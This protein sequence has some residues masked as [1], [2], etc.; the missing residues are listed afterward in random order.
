MLPGDTKCLNVAFSPISVGTGIGY[1]YEWFSNDTPDYTSPTSTGITTNTFPP[2]SNAVGTTYYYVVV[3]SPSCTSATSLVSG[4]YIVTANNTVTPASSSPVVCIG[5]ALP[6]PIT[7]TTVGSTGIGTPTGLPAGISAN[8]AAKA[9]T[10]YGTPTASGVFNYSIPLTGGCGTVNATGTITVNAVPAILT[11]SLS[12]LAKC[13]GTGN[14]SPIS[15]GT[16]QGFTYQWFSNDTPD[17]TSPTII[18]GATSNTYPPPAAT[19]GTTYYFVEVSSSGSCGSTVTSAVSGAFVVNPLPVVSFVTQPVAGNYCVDTDI[20]YSTQ[21]GETNYTWTIPGV[22]GTDYTITSGGNGSNTLVL[23]WLTSG[24]KSVSVNYQDAQGCGATA[25]ATSNSITVQKN[26]VTASSD[27]HPSSCFINRTITSFTHTTTLATGIGAP[28]GLPTGLSAV[29]SGNT[30]TVSGTVDASIL[31]GIYNYSIPLTGGCGTVAATGFIDVQPEYVFE[32]ITSV[33]PSNVGGI[34]TIRFTVDSSIVPDGTYEVTYSLGLANSG[35]GTVNVTVTNGIAVFPTI[36]ILSEDLT[37]LTISQ[38]KKVTDDCFVPLSANNVTFFGIQAV[39]FPSNGTFYVP[40][41]IYEITIKVWGGGGAGGNGPTGAGG[42]GGGY[43]SITIPVVP[44]EAIGMFIGTGGTAQG[45]G[46]FSYATRD[47]SDPDQLGSSL[48]YAN[49]GNGANGSTPGTGGSGQT[50]NGQNGEYRAT[51]GGKGG[52]AGGSGGNGAPEHNDGKK[53]E[54]GETPGGGGSGAN[55]NG[56]NAAGGNGGNGLIL[57][58]YPLPPVD[59][60]FNVIDDG[61]VS[62][63]TIIEFICDD[64]WAPPEGL[65]DFS[66]FV[67]GAGGGGGMGSG[68]GGGG[69]GALSTQ[70]VPSGSPYGFPANNDFTIRVGQGGQ[71]AQTNVIRGFRGGFSGIAGIVGGTPVLV[72][73]EGGGGGGS[74]FSIL[75]EGGL[76]GSNGGGGGANNTA[77]GDGGTGS[78]RAGGR[79]DF[80]T[81]QAFAG[82]GGGGIA[83]IGGEGKGAGLGQG[84]GGKGGNGVA[85]TMGDSTRYFG[86]GGGGVGFNFNGTQKIGFGGIAPN[87]TKLGGDGNLTV[88]NAIGQQGADKTGSG[89]GAGYSGGGKGGNGIVYIYYP[90]YRILGVEFGYF[91]AHYNPQNRSG[92]LRWATHKEW[93]NSHFEIERAVNGVSTWTKVGELKGQGYSDT[94]VEYEFIDTNLPDTGG[95]IYYR[96]REVN[97]NGLSGVSEVRAIQVNPI[98]E[99][100][101]W[102]AYPNPSDRG[103][104][105]TVT[106]Q[107]NSEYADGQFHVRVSDVRGI[108]QNFTVKNPQEVSGVIN[109]HL[110]NA[111]PGL[112]I[113]QIFWGNRSQ[114]LK[115]VRQ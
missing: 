90:T 55:G 14:F 51:Y 56:A 18:P 66:T 4:A 87:G 82:G 21:G 11:P 29:W 102:T 58:S 20:S 93:E 46:G 69:S 40:A 75:G 15:V 95:H 5:A 13:E 43:S 63:T 107:S 60:C 112:Y 37:S 33:S 57:V 98:N 23:R 72:V 32:S 94:T 2:P 68:A 114:H 26:T 101:Y 28:T 12:G 7:H 92:V 99:S 86:A 42:G 61:A 59:P 49:G 9:I 105:V 19:P 24:S 3:S 108:H 78:G 81:N 22:L 30:I 36:P 64:S 96:I 8:W 48:V 41:G 110:D 31:P 65:L 53:G 44:G 85:I 83:E 103:T 74:E 70:Y 113:V 47:S 88:P 100:S 34:A 45:N 10:I 16:G 27:P 67:G 71:G 1:T 35:G 80:S 109:S 54:P 17:Y 97:F 76:S 62:G 91:T 79:G 38:I 89:G 6:T 115:L 104:Q 50:S 77:E 111:R 25:A 73:A 52:N 106:L 39:T 84:E